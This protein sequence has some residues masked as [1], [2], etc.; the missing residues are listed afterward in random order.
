MNFLNVLIVSRTDK[1]APTPKDQKN[2]DLQM[3]ASC[4]SKRKTDNYKPLLPAVGPAMTKRHE[5]ARER[6][7]A[8]SGDFQQKKTLIQLLNQATRMTNQ[9]PKNILH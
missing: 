3:T 9:P 6:Q 4:A 2:L 5:E 8:R 1:H 7:G